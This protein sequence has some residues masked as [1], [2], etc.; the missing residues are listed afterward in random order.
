MSLQN[1][2]TFLEKVGMK[3]IYSVLKNLNKI[4]A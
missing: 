1:I 4:N 2:T 3:N